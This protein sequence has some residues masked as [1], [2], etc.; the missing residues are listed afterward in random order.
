[1]DKP[2][3]TLDRHF[4]LPHIRQVDANR[5]LVWLRMGW[6]DMRANLAASLVYGL[7][8]AAM[9]YLILSYAANLP[10]LFTASIS[11]FFLIGPLAAA[12][13]YEISRC[14]ERGQA[15]SFGDSL[16]G[17]RKHGDHLL[18]FGTFLA[19]ILLGWER[20]SAILFALFYH[21]ASPDLSNFFQ[22]VFLSGNYTH[23]VVS[24]LV[25]GGAIAAV[26]FA[27]SV[28]SVPLL[29][30]READMV[31]AMMT[32]ARAVGFNLGA[33]TVWATLIVALIGVGFATMM[34]GM[35]V[36]LPL[37]GHA[38]WHAYRDLVE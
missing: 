22:D 7:L 30:D 13:L 24:Y 10:Y 2:L 4:H 23:F 33:M 26:V 18:Y 29:M 17:L 11:G 36:L 9:G 1:M 27:L 16:C 34:L 28:V 5:P 15:L 6:D 8:F 21:G 20:L 38:T 37:L 25:V 3:N 12:G 32:S 14:H 19:F 35:I 31:T